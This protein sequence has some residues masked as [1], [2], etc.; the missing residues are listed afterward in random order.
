M[1]RGQS[2]G[3]DQLF[4][5]PAVCVIHVRVTRT[6]LERLK[7]IAEINLCDQSKL[8]RDAINEVVSDCSDDP[9]FVEQPR[10][11]TAIR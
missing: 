2:G 8:I 5:E 3:E 4:N 9:L 10:P 11:R 7:K 1:A 6:Q